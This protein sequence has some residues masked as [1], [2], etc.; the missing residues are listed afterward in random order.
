MNSHAA[1]VRASAIGIAV[2]LSIANP[3][4]AGL[5][6]DFNFST[7]SI[8]QDTTANGSGVLGS[9][10]TGGTLAAGWYRD[11]IYAN[12][13]TG[14]RVEQADCSSCGMGHF[15][16]DSNTV[17]NGYESWRLGGVQDF[18]RTSWA[19]DYG[20]DVGGFDVILY[21]YNSRTNTV[22]GEIWWKDIAATG[23]PGATGTLGGAL[24]D[25]VLADYIFIEEFSVGGAYNPAS[26]VNYGGHLGARNF[27]LA[28]VGGDF[29]KDNLRV[30]E[31][32]TLALL[33]LGL[34]GLAAWR[35]RVD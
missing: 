9:R 12:L 14:D 27:N 24:G 16:S 8:I 19:I 3:A 32:A 13:V 7:S 28:S 31:P 5:I 10:G 30:P 35:R 34:V 4:D 29:N 25:G 33:G 11:A 17:G 20:L 21:F 2:A 15:N 18:S 1:I 26:A 22:T 23:L 6:D